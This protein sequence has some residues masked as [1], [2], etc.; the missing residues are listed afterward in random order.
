MKRESLIPCTVSNR[1]F[2][3][4]PD[5]LEDGKVAYMDDWYNPMS[6]SPTNHL[7]V[8]IQTATNIHFTKTQLARLHRQFFHTT[9]KKL[10]NLISHSL[11]GE[12]SP[13]T[14][15]TLEDISS[16]CDPCQRIQRAP[17]RF[18]KSFGAED[19]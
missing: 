12:A 3:R 8:P 16:R 11:P 19:E 4:V 2:H 9:A 13:E 7:Y 6:R 1:F 14:L 15:M 17:T 18:R 10:F 5:T